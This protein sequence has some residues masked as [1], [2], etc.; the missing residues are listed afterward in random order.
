M[1][2]MTRLFR[3]YLR[4][5]LM[6]PLLLAILFQYS[7]TFAALDPSKLSAPALTGDEITEQISQAY[8]EGTAVY[9][10]EEEET[11]PASLIYN[12]A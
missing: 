12:S 2:T 11:S 3:K 9:P 6:A 4:L 10:D 1:K 8:E 7:E 5:R